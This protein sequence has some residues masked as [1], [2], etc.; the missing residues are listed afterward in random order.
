[1][2]VK[3][4]V[5]GKDVIVLGV[6]KKSTAKLQDPR[7][8]RKIVKLDNRVLLAAKKKKGPSSTNT[9][10]R[11]R[12]RLCWPHRRRPHS[13]QPREDGVSIIQTYRGGCPK[14]T[15]PA[16]VL[17]AF[18]RGRIHPLQVEYIARYIAGIQQKYTQSGGVR[19]FGIST[20][21]VGFD[22]DG[23][24]RLYQTDPS[25]SFSAWK[26]NATGKNGKT[27]REYL[28][29]N[30]TPEIE[31]KAE[32]VIRLAV[33][34][35]MEVAE[36]GGKNIEIALVRRNQEMHILPDEELEKVRSSVDLECFL[37]PSRLQSRLR[38]RSRR[39]RLQR[40]L[41][42]R[43]KSLRLAGLDLFFLRESPIDDNRVIKVLSLF[44]KATPPTP[45]VLGRSCMLPCL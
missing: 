24:S 34:A 27:V 1:M 37:T 42:Q 2:S 11:H 25:G 39:L 3:V 7:T 10:R 28:E 4:A 12:L 20:L 9:F 40:R 30:Y 33:R 35:L 23:T 38:R 41:R 26:A 5:R 6:E 14:R 21:I 43:L 17:E 18:L 22:Q 36:A 29:K 16:F 31:A 19:P 13:C 44:Q 8:I 45:T 15:M 32:D